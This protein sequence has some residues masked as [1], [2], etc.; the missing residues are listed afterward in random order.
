MTYEE[1][2]SVIED[3][4]NSE[5]EF[6]SAYDLYTLATNAFTVIQNVLSDDMF[7]SAMNYLHGYNRRYLRKICKI[8]G[9]KAP[10]ISG[11]QY[12]TGTKEED[13]KMM[14]LIIMNGEENDRKAWLE[15]YTK[16]DKLS[17]KF[18]FDDYHN[19]KNDSYVVKYSEMFLKSFRNEII[20]R[21]NIIKSI[22]DTYCVTLNGFDVHAAD[23]YQEINDGIFKVIF[24]SSAD[25]TDLNVEIGFNDK[26]LNNT[27]DAQYLTKQTLA[28]YIKENK[29][30]LLS[31]IKVNEDELNDFY[32]KISSYAIKKQSSAKLN[33]HK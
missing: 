21:L 8:D 20:E 33:L 6:F 1:L 13:N 4:K 10:F 5:G 3:K 24:K 17:Y 25:E 23:K 9:K 30:K 26:E 32:K 12:F 22:K 15:V 27:K 7:I 2:K 16:N 28:S 29:M 31:K 18:H 11:V 14:F 19:E